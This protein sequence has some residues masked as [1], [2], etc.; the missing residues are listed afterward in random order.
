VGELCS[1]A[2]DVG[3]LCSDASG[4]FSVNNRKCSFSF[5]E[6]ANEPETLWC[7][8]LSFLFTYSHDTCCFSVLLLH[9]L[10]ILYS[11]RKLFMFTCFFL[12]IYLI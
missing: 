9:Y 4:V 3:E 10:F 12:F 7:V 8:Q 2:S 1:D 11:F 6:Q 5:Q